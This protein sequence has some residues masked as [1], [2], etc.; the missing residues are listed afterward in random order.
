ME[1]LLKPGDMI[2]I[3]DDIEEGI[4][5]CMIL[6]NET[7]NSWIDEDMLPA[8]TLVKII[9]ISS[10][11]YVVNAID[12]V[13]KKDSNLGDDFWLYTD[14]MFDPESLALIIGTIVEDDY[15]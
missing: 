11:Q 8:G 10:G 6:D 3:R 12:Y 15:F 4:S 1:T 7:T 5:Y 13:H 14:Q 9:N 2:R